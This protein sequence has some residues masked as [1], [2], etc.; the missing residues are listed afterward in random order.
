[1]LPVDSSNGHSR[2]L[3]GHHPSNNES[4][5]VLAPRSRSVPSIEQCDL[6]MGGCQKYGPFLGTL[7][8][9]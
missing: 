2:W 9:R 5:Q 7:N 3:G 4:I 6:R 1:M 8:I